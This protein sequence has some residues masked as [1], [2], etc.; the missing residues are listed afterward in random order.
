MAIKKQDLYKVW[1]GANLIKSNIDFLLNRTKP[2]NFPLNEESKQ[3]ITDL[4]DTY[5]AVPCAGIAANQ[6]G[7][8]ARIFIGMEHDKEESIEDDDN[9]N[10]DNVIPESD[11]ME[12]YINPK[13]TKNS[14]SSM[15]LGFEGCLSIPGV[16]LE[17]ER[18]DNMKVSYQNK[19]GEI[20][21][22]KI[23]G[24]ISRLFQHE[25]DHLNGSLMIQKQTSDELRAILQ[26]EEYQP[27]INELFQYTKV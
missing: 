9:Q 15:Q 21:I 22:K 5:Q 7:H 4:E 13:I 2:V 24:F 17:I 14:L 18:Y 19:N 8:S 11:N 25:L 20:V 12:M 10:I 23:S 6:I 26:D 1:D 3:I 27:L 16:Q